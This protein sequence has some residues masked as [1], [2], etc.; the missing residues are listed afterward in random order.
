MSIVALI[1]GLALVQDGPIT[2]WREAVRCSAVFESAAAAEW[3]AHTRAPAAGHDAR[4]AAF[5]DKAMSLLDSMNERLTLRQNEE[6]ET[7]RER[8]ARTLA[9]LGAAER[10]AR[11][12]ACAARLP[13]PP[14]LPR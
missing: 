14:V 7:I 2:D 12:E 9:G 11:A 5:D 10:I 4:S 6:A 13:D 3:E 8:E 1:A